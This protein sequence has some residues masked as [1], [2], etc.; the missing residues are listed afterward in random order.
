[1]IFLPITIVLFYLINKHENRFHTFCN[2]AFFSAR[3]S[4][5]TFLVEGHPAYEC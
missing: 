5:I 3:I 2:N 1:M 4:I